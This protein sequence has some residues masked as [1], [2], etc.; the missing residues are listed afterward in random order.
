M[1]PTAYGQTGSGKTHSLLNMVAGDPEVSGLVP[2][3]VQDLFSRMAK[4][5]FHDYMVTCSF[6]Q[7]SVQ[8]LV[9]WELR[10]P[11]HTC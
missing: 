4:D 6:M 7:V 11:I 8:C 2:R 3:V 9:T 5:P 1:L 10:P